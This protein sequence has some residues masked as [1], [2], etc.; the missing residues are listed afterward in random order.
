[1]AMHGQRVET[2]RKA[3]RG[4]TI[5]ITA[6]AM[7]AMLAMAV[8]AIDIVTLYVASGQAQK[9]ADAAALAGAKVFVSSGFTSGQLGLPSSAAAQNLVCNGS[10][11]LS[12]LQAQAAASQNLIAGTAPTT[13]TTSC[14]FPSA[15][16][17]QITVAVTRTGLP[18]FFARI[19]GGGTHSASASAKAEAYNPSGATVPI[20][21]KNVKPWLI[22]NCDPTTAPPCPG[23]PYFF[24]S[25]ANY[26]LNNP[27]SYIGK[28]FIFK[29]TKNPPV[30]GGY[31]AIDLPQATV[32]PS[33]LRPPIGSC[34]EVSS[35]FI[36]HDNIACANNAQLTC[37]DTVNI[38]PNTATLALKTK[39]REGTQCLMHTV[40]NG[41]TPILCTNDLDPDC[42]VSGPPVSINGGQ[43]NPNPAMRGANISRSDSVVTVPIFDFQTAADDPCPGGACGSA[44]VIGFL[45]LG[46]QF[47]SNP[48]PGLISGFVLNAAG[49]DPAGSGTAI[50]GGGV[51][52][53]PV[54]LI[55]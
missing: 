24:D 13:V 12:D 52:P 11:G 27:A 21:V 45:Q 38:D 4:Q 3:E 40:A 32:C 19:W 42:F 54:R 7:V 14:N 8:L 51:S 15:E 43:S 48:G 39:A 46:I 9:T 33:P 47:V 35:G 20:Q 55:Q 29:Q 10:T 50:S 41:N 2:F 17:P 26:A 16:N 49:C 30:A 44:T 37:G 34:D 1:M 5:L 23:S 28:Y 31:Y 25:S 6:I 22:P 18:T 53:I 36:F